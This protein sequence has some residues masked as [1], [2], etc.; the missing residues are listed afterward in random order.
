MELVG[1]NTAAEGTALI[2]NS[3]FS[4]NSAGQVVF[5][6]LG[7]L[8]ALPIAIVIARINETWSEQPEQA[9]QFVGA[10]FAILLLIPPTVFIAVNRGATRLADL[11]M[12]CVGTVVVLLA[13][14]YLYWA[15][16][17][18][19]FPA[20]FL[21]WSESDYVNDILKF[22]A[23][24]PIFSPQVNNDSFTY[25][26]GSQ[27]LTYLL[28]S[29]TGQ[30]VSLTA[31]RAIQVVYTISAS[32]VAFLC[33]RRLVVLAAGH[34]KARSLSP[35]L[36]IVCVIGLFLVATNA[37]TDPFTAFLH[38][39][40][41]A[42]LVT[43]TAYWLLLKYADT[44]NRSIFWLMALVP[45]VGFWVKQN[46]IVW[47][48]L[49]FVY[50]LC[51]DRPRSIGRITAFTFVSAA[52]TVS[53]VLLGFALWGDDFKYWTITV[54]GK[55]GVSPLRSFQ[56]LLEVWPYLAAALAGA[57]VLSQIGGTKK[58]LGPWLIWLILILL[59]TYTS[60]VAWMV[61]HIGPGT[62]IAGIWFFAA[63][64]ASWDRIAAA[65][66]RSAGQNEW[67]RTGISVAVI[68]LLFSGFGVI[69]IPVRPF[70]KD[71]YRYVREIEGEFAGE[72]ADRILLD[73]GSWIYLRD[74]IVMKDRAPAIGERGYSQTGDFSGI[75]GRLDQKYYSKILIRNLHSGNFWY[76]HE[77]W[78]RSSN[79]R[80]SLLKNYQE[81][82]TIPAVS[83]IAE[84]DM[85]YGFSEIS[86]LIPR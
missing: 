28:A 21:I 23:G 58:I 65:T 2:E 64:A 12:I 10:F 36:S 9:V 70:S 17:C 32:I 34:E 79:I 61:N 20:D 3:G 71:A 55:H 59:E 45:A 15:G 30:G 62:L 8:L 60:G 18:I 76:D 35:Y 75:L 72:P 31:L 33:C 41:L 83:G 80:D 14:C 50:V 38:N 19:T 73:M 52:F 53:S 84:K 57:A 74:G 47:A 25:V 67:F 78:G 77:T 29:L 42:Q 16:I 7:F 43:I 49:Y 27:L 44:K 11:S 46:L 5:G 40:A 56:H 69:R 63:V 51:F 1:A 48:A 54:L 66:V 13:A 37:I 81:V 4:S 85:P 6:L 22:R 26:P 82:R 24:Y 86:I 68:C 39:D